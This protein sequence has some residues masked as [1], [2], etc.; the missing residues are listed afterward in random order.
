MRL[1]H[2]QLAI[3][4]GTE[5]AQRAFWV[6][7]L[8][9]QERAKPEPLG[10]RGGVWLTGGAEV[11][12][13]VEPSHRPARKAHPAFRVE[14]LDMVADRLARAGYAVTWDDALPGE[15]RFYVD[16]PAGNRIEMM[17]EI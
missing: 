5:D 14:G 2:V 17:E 4:P 9:L 3:P 10:A 7:L 1:D 6:G 12:L 13:G 16:D 8:G 11:L 15:R